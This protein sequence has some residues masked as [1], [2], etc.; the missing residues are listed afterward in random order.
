MSKNK[1]SPYYG[2]EPPRVELVSFSKKGEYFVNVNYKV[3]NKEVIHYALSMICQKE[4]GCIY[5][6]YND[7][8]RRILAYDTSHRETLG[9]CHKH[10]PGRKNREQLPETECSFTNILDKFFREFLMIINDLGYTMPANNCI[11]Y[12][13][14]Y[15]LNIK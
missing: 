8:D 5:N 14:K 4:K 15:I 11:E 10:C 13:N 6:I 7:E 12:L 2:K 3:K 9:P 1:K